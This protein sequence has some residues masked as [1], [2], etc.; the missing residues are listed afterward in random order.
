MDDTIDIEIKEYTNK[1][2][3]K[4]PEIFL[5]WDLLIFHSNTMRISRKKQYVA[6]KI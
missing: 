3:G 5:C 1:I 6:A 2:T 4:I